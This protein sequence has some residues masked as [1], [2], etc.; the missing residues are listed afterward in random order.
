V[1]AQRLT[2]RSRDTDI[3]V[4]LLWFLMACASSMMIR[5]QRM[6]SREPASAVSSTQ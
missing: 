5:F 1:S 4:R 6:L 2:E 3:A